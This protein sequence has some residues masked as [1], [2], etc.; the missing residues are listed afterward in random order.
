MPPDR[1]PGP[2]ECEVRPSPAGA[3]PTRRRFPGLVRKAFVPHLRPVRLPPLRLQ[4][5]L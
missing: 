5:R 4:D 1:L 3:A 2:P